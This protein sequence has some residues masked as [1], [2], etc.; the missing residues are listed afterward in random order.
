[1]TVMLKDLTNIGRFSK[2]IAEG[3][4]GSSASR[5]DGRYVMLCYTTI[6]QVK[7]H[8]VEDTTLLAR[9]LAIRLAPGK[10]ANGLKS[11]DADTIADALE[12]AEV[13]ARGMR[14]FFTVDAA[15]SDWGSIRLVDDDE[16]VVVDSNYEID[17]DAPASV[18][19]KL[20]GALGIGVIVDGRLTIATKGSFESDE[21]RLGDGYL[22][23]KHDAE[24][25]ARFL[26]E[27][28]GG[29]FTPIFEII[30]PE[31]DHVVDYGDYAD[32]VL[33]GLMTVADGHW[34]P[35]ALLGS[36]ASTKGTGAD[37][38][39]SRFG[40]DVP[41]IYPAGS[42]GGALARKE[43]PDHEGM[44]VTLETTPQRMF[45]VKYPT[46]LNLQMLKNIKGKRLTDMVRTMDDEAIMRLETP[47]VGSLLPEGYEDAA[48]RIIS[49]LRESALGVERPFRD[50]VVRA[51]GLYD[52]LAEG[53]DLSTREGVKEFVFRVNALKDEDHTVRSILMGMKK[54]PGDT[55]SDIS[56]RHADALAVA[57]RML[58]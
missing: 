51:E 46:F 12:N 57:R 47:D 37:G 1:M 23:S 9:G 36:D 49:G 16:G 21:A 43:L 17:F 27:G 7:G 29:R 55:E 35:A 24:G 48:A 11:R 4:I 31:A 18:S 25:F 10:D 32:I 22:H 2:D 58:L 41:E 34:V 13:V 53:L 3:F 5:G 50:A 39:P 20:D 44:V 33:L 8:W 42:L 14:K 54:H 52:G 40:F 30:T 19:D 56:A 15:E 26:S 45:K 38:I 28:L 6:T